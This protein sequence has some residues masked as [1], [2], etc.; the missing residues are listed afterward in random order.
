MS[1]CQ[2]LPRVGG[3]LL[4]ETLSGSTC[5]ASQLSGFGV[6]LPGQRTRLAAAANGFFDVPERLH[7]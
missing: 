3:A 6:Q 5:S 2:H 7:V 4:T 1:P